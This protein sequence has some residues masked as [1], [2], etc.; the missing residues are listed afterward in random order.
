MGSLVGKKFAPEC[1]AGIGRFQATIPHSKF[2]F[3]LFCAHM[4][5]SE[6][7]ISTEN[8]EIILTSAGKSWPKPH[9]EGCSRSA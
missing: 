9:S 8:E 7:S 3:T 2:S 4:I 1:K 5:M 6:S